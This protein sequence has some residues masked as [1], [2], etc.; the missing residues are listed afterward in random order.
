MLRGRVTVQSL[1]EKQFKENKLRDI[2]ESFGV[3]SHLFFRTTFLF[4]YIYKPLLLAVSCKISIGNSEQFCILGVG[5]NRLF[6]RESEDFI[7]S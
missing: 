4:L 5:F 3:E 7:E 6:K 2:L 1:Y